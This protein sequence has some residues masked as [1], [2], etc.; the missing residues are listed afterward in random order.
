MPGPVHHPD[1][2]TRSSKGQEHQESW[3][4]PS[5]GHVEEALL[6]LTLC[7]CSRYHTRERSG[8]DQKEKILMAIYHNRRRFRKVIFQEG[9]EEGQTPVRPALWN[10]RAERAHV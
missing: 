3:C 8:E 2:V 5:A 9:G 6:T 7:P 1:D 4:W 10:L